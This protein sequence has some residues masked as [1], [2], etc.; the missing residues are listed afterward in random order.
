M[1]YERDQVL[2]RSLCCSKLR[3]NDN[4]VE[5]NY[6][7]HTLSL[8]L[9][10]PAYWWHFPLPS[11]PDHLEILST[12]QGTKTIL[13]YLAWCRP[14]GRGE[15]QQCSMV[16]DWCWCVCISVCPTLWLHW[17]ISAPDLWHAQTSSA[18]PLL[19]VNRPASQGWGWTT[20]QHRKIFQKLFLEF[21][22]IRYMRS[23]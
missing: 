6:T 2:M 18:Q 7:P 19:P 8:S 4:G 1:V 3:H 21:N 11:K 16:S 15:Q 17:L 14:R 9:L 13:L 20:N 12:H 23:L 5:T 10:Y 22:N